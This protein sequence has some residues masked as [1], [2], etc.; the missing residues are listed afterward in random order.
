MIQ[1]TNWNNFKVKFNNQEQV[2]FQHLCYLLF[3]KQFDKITGIFRFKN[4]AGIETNPVEKDGQVIGW[5]AKFYTTKLSANKKELIKSIDTTKERHPSLNT[6]FFYTNQEFS[7]DPKGGDPKC[8]KEIENHAKEKGVSIEWKQA[9]FFESSFVCEENFSIAQHFFALNK[10]IIDSIVL[11][12]LHTDSLLGSIRSEI[13][14]NGK[15]IKFDRTNIIRNLDNLTNDSSIVI[16]SGEAWIGKT[17]VIKDFYETIKNS[18]PLFVFKAT[19]FKN[20]THINELF[21]DYWEITASDFID[22]HE[23]IITKYLVI[24]SAEK[25]SEIEDQSIFLAFLSDLLKNGWKIILTVRHNYLD[26]LRFQLKEIYKVWFVSLDIPSITSEE[27]EKLAQINDFFL[28]TSERLIKLLTTPLY[29]NEYL[30]NYSS[31]KEDVSYMD[32]REMIWKKHIQNFSHKADNM[33]RRR[34]DCFL[35]IAKKRANDGG[36]YVKTDDCDQEALK[37]L[38]DDEIIKHDDNAGGYFITHDIY[39]EWGLDKLIEHAFSKAADY[40][41]FYEEIGSSLPIRRAFRNWLSDKLF[42]DNESIK[43]L[44]EFTIRGEKIE[45]HWKDEVLISVLLS[46][47]S[48]IFFDRFEQE[49]LEDPEKVVSLENS[50]EVITSFSIDYKYEEKLF[51]KILFLLRIACKMI[52]EDFLRLL[53]IKRAEEASF[54]AIFTK[55]KWN[56]WASVIAF[57]N[58]HKDKLRFAYMGTIL[59]VLSDWNRH[60]KEGETTKNASQI[61]LF[62][63]NELTKQD[64]FYFSSRDETKNILIKTILDGSMEIK[65]ELTQII[66]EI[67]A[68]NDTDHRSKHY[69]LVKIILSSATEGWEISKHLPSEV[70]SL[71]NL[72]WFH[73]PKEDFYQFSSNRNDIEEHFGLAPWYHAYYPASAFQTPAFILLQTDHKMAV[74]FILSFINKSIEYFA[75]TEF[76]KYEVWEIDVFID[77]SGG[78]VKQYIS[79]RLWNMYRGTQVAPQL[80]QSLHMALEKW[81]LMIAKIV[82]PEVLQDWCFYLIKNSRSASISAIVVSVVLAESSKLFNVAKVLFQTKQFFLF[83]TS[84][85]LLDMTTAKNTYGM[86]NDSLGFYKNERI[87]TCNDKHRSFSLENLALHYQAFG[88]KETVKQRKKDLWKIFDDY[89]DKLREAKKKN[90][91]DETWELYLARM[92]MRKMKITAEEQGDQVVLK[93]KPKVDPELRKHSKDSLTEISL[94]TK[95]SSLLFWSNYKYERNKD[96]E[97]YPEYENDPS[98]AIAVTKKVIKSLKNDKSQDKSFTS[99]HHPIPAYVCFVALRDYFEKLDVKEKKFCRDILIKYFPLTPNENYQMDQEMGVVISAFPLLLRLFPEDVVEIKKT[100]LFTFFDAYGNSGRQWLLDSAI[101]GISNGFWEEDFSNLNSIFLGFLRLKPIYEDLKESTSKANRKS[102]V[103]D[104]SNQKL[105]QAFVKNSES[106]IDKIILNEINF[107]DISNIDQIDLDILVTAFRMLPL[108]ISDKTQKDFLHK[109]FPLFSK[110]LFHEDYKRDS[111]D[112]F[113]KHKFIEKFACIILSSEVEEIESYLKPFIKDFNNSKNIAELFSEFISIEDRMNQYEQFWTVW[114]LFYP[115]VVDLVQKD[116]RSYS[117]EIIHNYLLAWG[118]G[119]WKETAKDWHTLKERE[120]QFFIKAAHDMGKNPS[121]LYSI[122]KFL[123]EIWSGFKEKG[124][125]WISDILKDNPELYNKEL[126]MNTVFYLENL[127]RSYILNNRYKIKTTLR[128]KNQ[129]LIIL[130]FLLAKSSVTAYLLRENIL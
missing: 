128:I 122:S 75:K 67:I 28:P 22:E 39:E 37:K 45:N 103:Y 2:A 76:A 72:F 66:N 97:K 74:D 100:L 16:V 105:F 21:R 60:Y 7:E 9:S 106:E 90:E 124:V 116:S 26:D 80:L 61:A 63:Y 14:F 104:F 79:T 107:A 82:T 53:G 127:I 38:E 30:Q 34:E 5:Q 113:D 3:C 81:L 102:G 23:D 121:T 86:S 17:A 92:D 33:H 12:A 35:K 4:Q 85:M 95:Y 25:L 10:G 94:L 55:P 27:N 20:I 83:D 51:H 56:G 73:V 69:E 44:I 41:I 54:N 70:I 24:D 13:S 91:N 18:S 48:S 43:Q 96:S 108:K 64:G 6:I 62:Y 50:S 88:E 84:R 118:H 11:L 120:E 117:K 15:Q 129:I 101:K 99:F 123:N 110:K 32:F 31:I 119:Y 19:Q 46:D 1:D 40:Q 42:I 77:D 68:K 115:K 65:S 130:D 93:F 8:K 57:I 114:K 111:E 89:Y 52:D 98:F 126:E 87:Q 58:K 29:L 47:Y 78:T 71:A 109:I 36:F 112:F 125:F 49:L 59:S